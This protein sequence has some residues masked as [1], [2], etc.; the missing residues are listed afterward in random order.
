MWQIYLCIVCRMYFSSLSLC[1]TS[2]VFQAIG[3]NVPNKFYKKAERENVISVLFISPHVYRHSCYV[4]ALL[5]F[6]VLLVLFNR[7]EA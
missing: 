6:V 4:F 5:I 7:V 3:K 2:F 1:N